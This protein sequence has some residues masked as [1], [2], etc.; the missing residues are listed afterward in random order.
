V[1][2]G[3]ATAPRQELRRHRWHLRDA[4]EVTRDPWTYQDY[5]RSSLAEFSIAKQ[6]Y[7]A[8][9]SGWFA[10][11]SASYLASGRPVVVEDTGFSTWLDTE[12]GVLRFRDREQARQAIEDLVARYPQ[13][14]EEA[15]QIAVDYFGSDRVLDD[16][17]ERAL[18]R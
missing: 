18:A 7:V 14:C 10:E 16:L 4:L 11:R 6:A 3:G 9:N 12:L 13:H 15:R 17:L 8:S 5:I 1:A 2:I